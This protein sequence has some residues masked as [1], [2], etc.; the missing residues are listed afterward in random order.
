MAYKKRKEK[1]IFIVILGK[2]SSTTFPSSFYLDPIL[3]L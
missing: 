3:C 2:C 1:I